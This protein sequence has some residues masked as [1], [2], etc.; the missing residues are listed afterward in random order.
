MRGKLELPLLMPAIERILTSA[1]EIFGRN[2]SKEF[3]ESVT[4]VYEQ[5][6]SRIKRAVMKGLSELPNEWSDKVMLWLSKHPETFKIQRGFYSS[7]WG[8]AERIVERFSPICSDL[9]FDIFEK[10]LMEYREAEVKESYKWKTEMLKEYGHI[11]CNENGLTQYILLQKMPRKRLSQAAIGLLGQLERKFTGY[12]LHNSIDS[13][14]RCVGSPIPADKLR[15]V[16]DKE[17]LRIIKKDWSGKSRQLMRMGPNYIGE[18]S[19]RLFADDFGHIAEQ[20]PQRFAN[21]ALYIP[22]DVY[23]GYLSGIL[24]AIALTNPPD[25]LKGTERDLWK[26]ATG[27][28]IEAVLDYV[29]YSEDPDQ[30][31][32]FCNLLEK[33]SDAKW[34]EKVLKRLINYA[35]KH[36]DPE[37]NTFSAYSVDA[38]KQ[39]IP[40]VVNSALNCVRG[41][42]AFVIAKLLFE[43]PTLLSTFEETIANLV[44]DPSPAVRVAA[45]HVCLPI[46]DIDKNRAVDYFVTV[47]EMTDDS[48]F[49]G[50]Y[51]NRF[52]SYAWRTH[53]EN[54]KPIIKRMAR[55]KNPEVETRGAGWATAIWLRTGNLSELKE[56][57][58]VGS[59]HQRKGAAEVS[60]RWLKKDAEV[61]RHINLLMKFFNDQDADV[62]G[63]AAMCFLKEERLHISEIVTLSGYFVNTKTFDDNPGTILRGLEEYTGNIEDYA[64]VLLSIGTKLARTNESETLENRQQAVWA[65]HIFAKIMLRLY[66]RTYRKRDKMLHDRCL[67]TW[68][69]LLEA[70]IVEQRTLEE[71]GA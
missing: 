68:D 12:S 69:K 55:S 8:P 5:L 41:R 38:N 16:T 53:L 32:S 1:G 62:R 70:G 34:P 21:L 7:C 40:D 71:I 61:S 30:A 13:R 2:H 22:K 10:A 44:N 3:F 42:A 59:I 60:A 67:D 64:D 52:I 23:P 31:I 18:V 17:W 56:E 28:Q 66:E 26:P 14:L 45:M 9:V 19:H 57:C 54:L 51:S 36:P 24:R 25:S 35:T 37:P 65:M 58:C 6:P 15:L 50:Q 29:E 39:H 49:E 4:S 43:Q 27:E 46:L 48:I 47:C 20:Q 11:V 63:K 33:R